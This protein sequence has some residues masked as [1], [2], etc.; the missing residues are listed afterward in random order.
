MLSPGIDG[1]ALRPSSTSRLDMA[2]PNGGRCSYISNPTTLTT[3]ARR[4][5]RVVPC[6]R[7]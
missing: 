5:T 3:Q 1:W 4:E 6:L 7:R 2:S